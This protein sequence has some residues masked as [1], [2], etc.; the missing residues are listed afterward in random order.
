ML[1]MYG[2]HFMVKKMKNYY[3][4][5]FGRSIQGASHI[6]QRI[7]NQDAIMWFPREGV[8]ESII[9][10]VSD[11]HGSSKSFFSQKGS[12]LAV[13]TSVN[14][15]RDY[16]I[17][18]DIDHNLS[19][20]NRIAKEHLPQDLVYK[21]KRAVDDHRW[22]NPRYSYELNML[23]HNEGYS[24]KHAVL[25]NRYLAY[26]A[27]LLSVL[28]AEQFILYIQLGDGDI[29]TVSETGEIDRPFKMDNRLIGD[30]T[31]SLCSDH[32]WLDTKVKFQP[33]HKEFPTLILLS[34]DGYS[35]SFKDDKSFIQVGFD[36][37]E[38]ITSEGFN[39]IEENLYDWLFEASSSG[40]GDDI[41]L[42]IM[43]RDKL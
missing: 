37:W 16:G 35:N 1:K 39:T 11:G 12:D 40:S 15:L 20:L 41:T 9:L 26:G 32:V 19:S 8:G 5:V 38:L 10:A 3:W 13:K 18:K 33:I 4:K 28:V 30:E 17:A 31:T 2:D 21:W 7:P 22:N 34:T 29:L 24:A 6:R 14:V 36:I 27:T 42:G 23:E 43:Y 25:E